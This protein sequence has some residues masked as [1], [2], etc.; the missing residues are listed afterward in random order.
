LTDN[1][2]TIGSTNLRVRVDPAKCVSNGKC[3]Y[4]APG[5]FVIDEETGVAYIDDE[6]RATAEFILAGAR[7]CPTNA[8]IVEQYNRRIHPPILGSL[9]GA[10]ESSDDNG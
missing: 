9:P 4:A 7:A 8:I 2:D 5:I 10:R 3:T 1:S 6:D